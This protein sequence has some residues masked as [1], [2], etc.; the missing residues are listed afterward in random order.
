MTLFTATCTWGF[1][2]ARGEG[3]AAHDFEDEGLGLEVVFLEGGLEAGEG[4][5]V[6]GFDA[7]AEGVGQQF[8]G[9]VTPVA[10][11][12]CQEELF[13][14]GGAGEG[15]AVGQGGADVEGLVIDLIAPAADGVEVFEGEA[16]GVHA[17]VAGAAVVAAEVGLEFLADGGVGGFLVVFGDGADVGRGSGRG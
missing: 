13:E 7:A 2:A 8:E 3:E 11:A 14:F 10:F 9:Q 12:L 17:G 5:Q 4:G 6:V 1:A 15:A 16:E